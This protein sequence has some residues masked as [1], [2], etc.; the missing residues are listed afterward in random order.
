MKQL[1]NSP[2]QQFYSF[3][4][5][6]EAQGLNNFFGV[7]AEEIEEGAYPATFDADGGTLKQG[8]QNKQ[9]AQLS[10]QEQRRGYWKKS[11]TPL[12]QG[13]LSEKDK[14][15][16]VFDMPRKAFLYLLELNFLNGARPLYPGTLTKEEAE[17]HHMDMPNWAKSVK[18]VDNV[19]KTWKNNFGGAP[20]AIDAAVKKGF[21]KAPY[22]AKKI[23]PPVKLEKPKPGKQSPMQG[24]GKPEASPIEKDNNY[25]FYSPEF[26]TATA[27][28]MATPILNSASEHIKASGVHKSNPF[29]AGAEPTDFPVAG[30]ITL[31]PENFQGASQVQQEEALGNMIAADTT[32]TAEQKDAALSELKPALKYM[33]DI[34]SYAD[35]IKAGSKHNKIVLVVTLLLGTAA[36][37]GIYK[38]VK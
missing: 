24:K 3:D 19:K 9:P 12:K 36:V 29:V 6:V 28:A 37:Y 17:I 7:T 30:D 4:D 31:V 23:T 5:Q 27:V 11:S 18:L 16:P 20:E 35:A 8:Q 10:K 14:A 33:N 25:N 34:G 32:L 1:V 15:K 2:Q 13:V 22:A 26:T 21:F 38:W